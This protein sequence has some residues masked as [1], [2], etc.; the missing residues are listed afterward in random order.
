MTE[1]PEHLL[2]RS[3]E[4]REALGLAQPGESPAPE[5]PAGSAAVEVTG[6]SA[7]APAA[8]AAPVPAAAAAAPP[9]PPPPKPPPP[10]IEAAFR[11]K[12]IPFWAMPVL[13]GLPIWAF[14]FA[15]TLEPPSRGAS[16]P[17]TLGG[18]IFASKCASCHGGA[19]EG[20]VGP[21]MANGAVLETWPDFKEQIK[22]VHLGSDGWPGGTYGAPNKPKRGGMP[23][24]GEKEG[25]ELTDLEIAQVVRY[26]REVL[27][28]GDPEPDLVAITDG[29]APPLDDQGNPVAA[30]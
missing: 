13:V 4:R 21:P 19:G 9:P 20:G 10:Y 11:R 12:R 15:F 5:T 26:E 1:I 16:D 30:P 7:P 23:A 24:W 2:R 6:E 3:R 22:W 27:G 25:G 14:V 18:Q 28:G 8:A 29:T 17:L